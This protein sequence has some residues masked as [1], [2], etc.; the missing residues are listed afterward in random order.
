MKTEMA[1]SLKRA[2]PAGEYSAPAPSRPANGSGR[3]QC[4]RR[5]PVDPHRTREPQAE[6]YPPTLEAGT[7]AERLGM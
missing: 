2:L 1:P 5:P 7:R 4:P 3:S 6:L